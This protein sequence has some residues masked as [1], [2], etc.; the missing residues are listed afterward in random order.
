MGSEID[1]VVRRDR[2]LWIWEGGFWGLGMGIGE[3]GAD[4]GLVGRGKGEGRW[5]MRE[6]VGGLGLLA[7][8]LYRYFERG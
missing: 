5:L 4:G 2:V 1:G 7:L 8:V 6:L 3:V